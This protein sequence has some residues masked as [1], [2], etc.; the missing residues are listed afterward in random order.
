M[1]T[2]TKYQPR[3]VRGRSEIW[4]PHKDGEIAFISP[5]VGPTSYTEAGRRILEKG[6]QVPTGD[7]IASLLH[8]AYCDASVADQPEF[9]EV[10]RTMHKGQFWIFNSNVWSRKGVYVLQGEETTESSPPLDVNG[11]EEI[12]K[13]GEDIGGIRFS[14]DGRVRF[15]PIKSYNLDLNRTQ[16]ELFAPIKSYNLDLNRTQKEF[17]ED[18]FIIASYGQEGAEKLGEVSATFRYR[19]FIS[20]VKAK[21]R[22]T[23]QTVSAVGEYDRGLHFDSSYQAHSYQ[24]GYA[25]GVRK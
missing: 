16:K 8:S 4:V 20:G 3:I 23:K 22:T 19:P 11:L 14:R 1:E 6:L 10:I 5:S 25:F 18:G 21:E 2:S 24:E 12:L 13:D 15:A 17:A 9:K 7:Y